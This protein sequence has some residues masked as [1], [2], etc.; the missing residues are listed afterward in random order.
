MGAGK[1]VVPFSVKLMR[2]T[3]LL[4]LPAFEIYVSSETVLYACIRRLRHMCVKESALN[5]RFNPCEVRDFVLRI[6]C[7]HF[8]TPHKRT[9]T[10]PSLRLIG[11]FVG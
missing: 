7:S 8:I 3:G 1:E 5:C 6:L 10:G 9:F 4:K 2:L 11:G